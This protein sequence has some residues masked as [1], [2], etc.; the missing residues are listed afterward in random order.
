MADA[1][2]LLEVSGAAPVL[3]DGLVAGNCAALLRDGQQE[4][5]LVTRSGK[6]AGHRCGWQDV[7]AVASFDVGRWSCDFFG[8]G[9]RPTSDTLPGCCG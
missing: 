9:I 1:S 2:L 4:L 6:A 8:E 7:A 5:L 3:P